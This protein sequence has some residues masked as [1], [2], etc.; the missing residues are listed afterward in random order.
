MISTTLLIAALSTLVLGAPTAYN[1]KLHESRTDLPASF[2]PTVVAPPA[3]SLQLC[4]ALVQHNTAREERLYDVSTPSSMHYVKHLSKKEVRISYCVTLPSLPT[5]P[6][7]PSS[8]G[9]PT[10]QLKLGLQRLRTD[11]GRHSQRFY[12]VRRREG[13]RPS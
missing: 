13:C 5:Q 7:S 2:S 10:P 11:L 4:I 8:A 9:R 3:T 12:A 1:L 6:Y